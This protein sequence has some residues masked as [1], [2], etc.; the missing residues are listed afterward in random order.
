ME[1]PVPASYFLRFPTSSASHARSVLCG[2]CLTGL[3]INNVIRHVN[4]LVEKQHWRSRYYDPLARS[5]VV[6]GPSPGDIKTVTVYRKSYRN[7]RVRLWNKIKVVSRLE[8]SKD[9]Y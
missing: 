6:R 7:L 2:G 4:P 3:D 5:R 9:A 1:R 8:E